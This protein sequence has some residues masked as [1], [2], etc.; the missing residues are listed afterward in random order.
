MQSRKLLSF[1]AMHLKRDWENV[2]ARKFLHFLDAPFAHLFE[3]K[4]KASS[5]ACLKNEERTNCE[6]PPATSP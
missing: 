3:P 4:K 5:L 1:K 6:D 2:A